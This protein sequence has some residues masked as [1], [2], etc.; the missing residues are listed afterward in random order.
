MN[1]L[2]LPA[3]SDNYIWML[4]DG[5]HALVVDPGE[6]EPV[7]QALDRL[8]LRLQAILVTH[9]HSDHVGGVQALRKATGAAVYGP[10]RERI[11]APA[12]ALAGGD[13]VE[14]LGLS[15]AVIDVPGHTAGHIAYHCTLADGAPLLFCGDTLFSGGCGR[16]FEGTP[17]Q[18]LAS[19]D[20][21]AALPGDTRICCAHEYTLSNLRFAHVVEPGNAALLHHSRECER[22]RAHNLP[23]LP[24]RMALERDINPFLR[25]RLPAVAAAARRRDPSVNT[26]DAVAVFAALREWK[27]EFR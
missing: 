6:A 17:A 8:G 12:V 25:V 2:P 15:F 20:A 4:H 21:L 22:L 5:R 26:T 23:T 10:A 19:L 18:M 27:N 1:L 7:L 14:A 11:P 3:F 13:Q 9:H 24:S 16:L